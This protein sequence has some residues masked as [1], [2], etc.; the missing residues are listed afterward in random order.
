ML[1]SSVFSEQKSPIQFKTGSCSKD[2]ADMHKLE[3]QKTNYKEQLNTST[4]K[5]MNTTVINMFK[6]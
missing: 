1:V 2:T 5:Y 4:D 6:C 3:K